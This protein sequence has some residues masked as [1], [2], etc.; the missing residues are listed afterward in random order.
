MQ[1]NSGRCL[2]LSA[3]KTLGASTS[4]KH[5]PARNA[6]KVRAIVQAYYRAG[7]RADGLF[8][9]MAEAWEA[10]WGSGFKSEKEM[11]SFFSSLDD[12]DSRA[13]EADERGGE[14]GQGV[15]GAL[16]RWITGPTGYGT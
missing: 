2:Q 11:I 6:E 15:T 9:V 12:E 1:E 14:E 4:T 7:V 13:S 8:E 5:S 3:S 16:R 10:R